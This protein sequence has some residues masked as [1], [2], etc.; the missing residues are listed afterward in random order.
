MKGTRFTTFFFAAFALSWDLPSIALIR[1]CSLGFCPTEDLGQEG[2]FRLDKRPRH[3]NPG[4]T[5]L[6]FAEFFPVGVVLPN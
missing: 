6:A 3:R 2:F 5:N 4:A 1:C